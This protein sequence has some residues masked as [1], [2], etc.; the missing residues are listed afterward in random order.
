MKVL[1]HTLQLG[2]ILILNIFSGGFLQMRYF[3][4]LIKPA[5]SLCNMRCR[6][7][8]Y[9]DVV[10]NREVAS[11]GVMDKETAVKLIERAFEYT[12][13]PGQLTFAFQGGEPTLA[14]LDYYRFFVEEVRSRQQDGHTVAYAIQTNGQV[15]DE[16]WCRFLKE[17]QFLVG[18]SL[19]GPREIH[20][21][22]RLDSSLKGT[23]D[24]TH[25][26]LNLL[27]RHK[28][29]YNVLT[30]LTKQ[31][32]KKPQTL[33]RFFEKEKIDYVQVIPCLKALEAQDQPDK[34]FDLTPKLYSSFL[35]DF[36]ALWYEGLRKDRY[37][38]VRQFDN[39]V[40]MMKG[41]PAEQCGMM[42]FCSPQFVV[43]ADGGVYPCDFYVLDEYYSGNI[44]TSSFEEIR[45]A[46]GTER[47][48][49][50]EEPQNS[51]CPSCPVRGLCGGGC[52][53]YRSFYKAE[54]GYC[55]YQDFL[56]DAYDRLREIAENVTLE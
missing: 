33:Y 56:C 6:Y 29:E 55:P 13:A 20:D 3:S 40:W 54:P 11:Y 18:L 25:R 43:E 50:Y 22:Q 35:K 5:S 14:G 49:K 16:E 10:S 31:T 47:F 15:L 37:I 26:A 9:Y 19:D 39:L 42:G 41:R 8:F 24:T 7:C 30:V 53:R 27:K 52:K 34:P 2:V 21:F 12:P 38:S 1:V 44:M 36:F 51:L 46:A 48:I 45:K 17:N 4:T 32:A 28:I 23:F